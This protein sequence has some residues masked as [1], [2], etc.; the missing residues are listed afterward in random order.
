M[1]AVPFPLVK[2]CRVPYG[3]RRLNRH[4]TRWAGRKYSRFK[5]RETARD[6]TYFLLVAGGGGGFRRVRSLLFAQSPGQPEVGEEAVV[7]EKGGGGGGGGGR[8]WGGRARL[9][10]AR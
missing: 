1:M 10:G 7:A 4:L 3:T 5:H 9:A 6:D 8:R 2:R